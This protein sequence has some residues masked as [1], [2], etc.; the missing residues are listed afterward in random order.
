M[1]YVL[2]HAVN[3]TNIVNLAFFWISVPS[4][5]IIVTYQIFNGKINYKI[6]LVEIFIICLVSMLLFQLGYS[7]LRGL[8]SY[9]DY[10]LLKLI[11]IEGNFELGGQEGGLNAVSGWPILHIFS[12]IL[13][14]FSNINTLSIAKFF[15]SF[16]S[17]L[18][19][20][21]LFLLVFKIYSDRKIA[22]LACLIFSTIPKFISFE[23]L[24]IRESIAL[25]MMVFGFYL[26]Y[27]SRND[28]KFLFIFILI[29]PTII[30]A[31]HFT[32]FLFVILITIYLMVSHLTPY[33]QGKIGFTN[34]KGKINLNNLLLLFSVSLLSYW[35]YNAIIV[36][37]SVGTFLNEALGITQTITYAEQTG[38]LTSIITLRGLII[39][40]GFFLFLVIFTLLLIAKILKDKNPEKIEDGSFTLFFLFSGFYGFVSLFLSGALIIPDRLL[41]FGWLF[42]IIPIT[43]ILKTL[44]IK[45][46]HKL[47]K[48]FILFLVSFMFF[49]VYNIDPDFINKKYDSIDSIAGDK[50][51]A[52]A[53]TIIFPNSYQSLNYSNFY[54]GYFGAIGAIYDSQGIKPRTV[55]RS[56]SN[57]ENLDNSSTI[58]IINENIYLNQDIIKQKSPE[59]YE[60]IVKILSYKN[61]N[62]INRIADLGNGKYVLKGN[63][64]EK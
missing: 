9:F 55:G 63:S 19:I 10:D 39:Y 35:L 41:T 45:N 3:F 40:Y 33:F 21:P 34:L 49:N 38:I 52:I 8:D 64:Y 37:K 43:G 46:N 58:A 15:P 50:E 13:S 14:L 51:Y 54:Y 26:I 6:I 11:L 42:A 44:S 4:M 48:V 1:I 27:Q 16:L 57:M 31:H 60:R 36:L 23:S 20:F 56:L 28:K 47:R 5:I 18:I 30:L 7:G 22:L 29:I 53:N 25:F 2:Y 62:R 17:S 12:S 59:E 32:S 61:S 24:F